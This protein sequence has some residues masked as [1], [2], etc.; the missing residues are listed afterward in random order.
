MECPLTALIT[1]LDIVLITAA[2]L[3]EKSN[4]TIP[5]AIG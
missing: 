4:K 3:L 2:G 5:G 1:T